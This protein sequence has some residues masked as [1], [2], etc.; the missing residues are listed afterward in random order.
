LLLQ[1][2]IIT[3]NTLFHYFGVRL[4]GSQIRVQDENGQA[5]AGGGWKIRLILG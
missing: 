1:K 3:A 2:I 4:A 5:Y